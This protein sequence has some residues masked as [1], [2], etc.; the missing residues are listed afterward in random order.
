MSK[1]ERESEKE[2]WRRFRWLATHIIN[3]SMKAV[4]YDIRPEQLL[5]FNDEIPPPV[6]PEEREK[7]TKEHLKFMK[8]KFWTLFETDKD[9]N[10]RI[11][12]EEDYER[13]MKKK[14]SN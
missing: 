13:I 7:M 1:K 11:F 5:R 12:D 6:P 9:G 8:S 14:E 3:I 2:E 10:V 4:K